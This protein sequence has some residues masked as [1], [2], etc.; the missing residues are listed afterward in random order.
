MFM[1]NPAL[2]CFQMLSLCLLSSALTPLVAQNGATFPQPP[3]VLVISR[4][5]LKPGKSPSQHIKAESA[6]V[7]AMNANKWPTHYFAMDSMSGS[8]RTLFLFAFDSFEAWE[9]D[10]EA[11]DKNPAL[12]SALDRAY[13]GDGDL[14]SHYETTAFAYREDMS[15]RPAADIP[16]M[17]YFEISQFVIRPGHT[18]EFE[19]LAKLY[20]N[21]YEKASPDAR[22]AVFE[23]MYGADSGGVFLVITP[24]KSLSEVDSSL[25]DSK[26]FAAALGEDGMKKLSELTASAVASTQTNLFHFNPRISY[27]LDAWVQADP[28]FWKSKPAAAA[29]KPAPKPVQ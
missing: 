21:G 27:P 12:S 19:D 28:S 11:S 25:A 4:E 22:W 13:I 2:R 16:H 6:Y 29:T 20:M 3:K 5:Y 1:K 14:L 26:K 24:Y 10:A 7:A 8:P 9:K 18:K 17:R 23:S 15:L